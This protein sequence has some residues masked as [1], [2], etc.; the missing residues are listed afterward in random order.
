MSVITSGQ[1]LGLQIADSL[2]MDLEATKCS[3]GSLTNVTGKT[4][5]P[6]DL[7][8]H[9]VYVEVSIVDSMSFGTNLTHVLA[10]VGGDLFISLIA[11]ARTKDLTVMLVDG[12]CID[13]NEVDNSKKLYPSNSWSRYSLY[14]VLLDGV[15]NMSIRKFEECD[16]IVENASDFISSHLASTP[17]HRSKN[18]ETKTKGCV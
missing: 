13:L 12:G 2:Y 5:I 14:E 4:S 9:S 3:E 11:D 18:P 6:I 10:H 7:H 1:N 17:K 15:L 8:G 16:W